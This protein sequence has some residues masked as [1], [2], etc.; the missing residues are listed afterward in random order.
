MYRVKVF[1]G[2]PNYRKDGTSYW[3]QLDIQPYFG[4]N[5]ELKYYLAVE[6]D[7]TAQHRKLSRLS[8]QVR[9]QADA[10]R[11]L[12]QEAHTDELTRAGNRKHLGEGLG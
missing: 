2:G 9:R 6:T 7:V 11:S 4:E 1:S 5:G 3:L 10:R 12:E 8:D